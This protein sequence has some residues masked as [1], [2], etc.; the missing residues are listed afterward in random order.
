LDYFFIFGLKVGGLELIAPM[1]IFGAALATDLSWMVGTLMFA[2]FC[3]NVAMEKSYGTR[4]MRKID[5]PLL[6]RI[7]KYGYPSGLQ[8]FLEVFSMLFFTLAM[9]KLDQISLAAN[10]MVFSIESITFFPIIGI[11]QAV[12]IL[13]GHAIGRNRPEDGKKAAISG[14]VLSTIYVSGLLIC[15]FFFPRFFLGLFTPDSLDPATLE[16]IL[17]LGSV[18]L[19][20]VFLFSLFDG[21][22]VCCFGAMRGAGDVIFPMIAMGFW[23]VMGIIIPISALFYFDLANI[24]TMWIAWVTWVIALS[25]TFAWRFWGGK[26]MKK[27][28]IERVEVLD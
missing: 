7:I 18:M 25:A 12:S 22:Y 23:G 8:L 16:S 21:F 9:A 19:R 20:F 1:G 27:R 6:G 26:W 14:I 24:Y 10:N 15:F 17:S 4:S 2:Y 13:V 5:L 28:L 3:F 11:G